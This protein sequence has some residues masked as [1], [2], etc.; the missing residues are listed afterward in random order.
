MLK[1]ARFYELLDELTVHSVIQGNGYFVQK[2]GIDDC[3]NC[4][5]YNRHIVIH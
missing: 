3:G 2:N 4:I 1:E 5:H